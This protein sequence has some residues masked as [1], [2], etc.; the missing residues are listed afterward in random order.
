MVLI[1]MDGWASTYTGDGTQGAA[2]LGTVDKVRAIFDEAVTN[3]IEYAE[4]FAARE[5]K[6]RVDHHRVRPATPPPG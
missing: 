5:F 2:S 3:I 6:P 4:E 1:R